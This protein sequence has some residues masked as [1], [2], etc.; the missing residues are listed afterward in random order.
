MSSR[1]ITL[2]NSPSLDFYKPINFDKLSPI[3]T[4][5]ITNNFSSESK[6]D[7]LNQ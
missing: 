3:K 5:G 4:K 7:K 2:R 6:S 1:K